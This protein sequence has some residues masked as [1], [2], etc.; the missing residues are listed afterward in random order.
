MQ[1]QSSKS[2]STQRTEQ[3]RSCWNFF[4]MVK[5]NGQRSTICS[6]STVNGWR[7]LTWQCDVTLGFTWQ[8]VKWSRRVRHVG[9]WEL[10]CG[11]AW[12]ILTTHE[13]RA[14]E[15]ETSTDRWRHVWCSFWLFLVGFC[16][17][18]AILSL[19][20]F[21]LAIGWAE[22]WYPRVAGTM[23]LTAVTHFWQWL[24]NEGEGSRRT[25]EM[26]IGTKKLEEWLW[27]HV[28]NIKW[29]RKTE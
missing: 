28:N 12:E 26:S 2:E 15:A 23:G 5:V 10:A 17:G 3:D 16:L 19:Y 1:K 11:S 29:K 21:A 14:R 6:K 27:Y 13:A 4:T 7:V 24:L 18:L 20:A 9:A 22:R 25:P 8:Y